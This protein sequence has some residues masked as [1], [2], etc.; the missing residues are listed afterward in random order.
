MSAS[1]KTRAADRRE[2]AAAAREAARKKELRQRR[3]IILSVFSLI[4]VLVAVIS[5]VVISNQSGGKKV[6]LP[7]TATGIDNGIVVGKANAPVKVDFYED[8]QCPICGE[9]ESQSGATINQLIDSG[10]V[11]ATY[12]MMAFLG[13]E[14]VRAANAAAAA[15]QA[16]KFKA[17]HD[18]LYANQ[19]PE[20]TGGFQNKTL[21]SLASKVGISSTTFTNAV[22][23]STY[24]G[25]ASKVTDDAS[26]R[27]VTATPTVFL[28]GKQIPNAS[29]TPEGIT[30]AVNAAAATAGPATGASASASPAAPA[31]SASPA[32][33]AGSAPAAKPTS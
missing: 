5:V 24:T 29:L 22:N 12:H 16:G 33:P 23:D 6:V 19:P 26:K 7:A 2:K 10:K 21:I 11:Q 31:G 14:S 20:N 1:S 9:L 13:P 28:N 25:Y 27:G 32:A 4:I 15:A 3:I 17:Y 18:T 30:A 8:F